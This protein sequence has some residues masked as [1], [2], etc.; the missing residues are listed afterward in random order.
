MVLGAILL[1]AVVGLG[2]A[3]IERERLAVVVGLDLAVIERNR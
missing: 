2:G 3:V 1:F